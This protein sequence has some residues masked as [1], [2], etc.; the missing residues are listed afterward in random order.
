MTLAKKCKPLSKNGRIENVIDNKAYMEMLAPKIELPPQ[1]Q[2]F[3]INIIG[4]QKTVVEAP[5]GVKP[6]K[7]QTKNT[8][9]F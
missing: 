2:S 3:N 9:G 1:N 7:V 5:P 4:G 8:P 6:P